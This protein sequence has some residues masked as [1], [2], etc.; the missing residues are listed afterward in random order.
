MVNTHL[1]FAAD[2]ALRFERIGLKYAIGGSVASSLIGEPRS[3]VDVDFALRMTEDD[4]DRLLDAVRPL[5]YVPVET[6]LQ[7]VREHDSFNIIHNDAALKAD[8]FVLG[9]GVLDVNQ[10]ER[11]IQVEVPTV[12]PCQLWITAPEDQVLRK[13]DW[14][15][16]GGSVSERQWRDV[17]AILEIN[18]SELDDDYLTATAETTG[19]SLLLRSARLAART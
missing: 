8:L 10:I 6:A 18:E 14:Y 3:T 4:F 5:F 17:V 1:A 11:R 12:P 15:Q 7:A 13:L 2:L 9:S 19:L 16:R